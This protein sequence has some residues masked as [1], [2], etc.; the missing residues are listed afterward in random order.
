[1]PDS[2]SQDHLRRIV[3]AC[4]RRELALGAE[5]PGEDVELVET[6]ILD[7]MAWVSFIRS[8]ESTTGISDAGSR[9]ADRPATITNVLAV[10][11]DRRFAGQTREVANGSKAGEKTVAA[12]ALVGSA[13]QPGSR[14]VPSEIVDREYGMPEGKL[15]KRAGIESVA[16]AAEG[17]NEV[18]LG[19]QAANRALQ[20]A[21][22]GAQKID[23][24]LA[25]SET[26][27]AYP[28]IGAEL[29]SRLL[30]RETCGVLDIGGACLGFLNALAAAHALI[31]AGTGRVILIV[32]ADVHSRVLTP[33]R[34]SG[35]FGGLFGDGASA[36]LLQREAEENNSYGYSCRLGEFSFGCA[37]Q[38]A[39]AIRVAHT[40]DG[41]LEVGFAGDALSRAAVTRLEKILIEL[42]TRSGISRGQVGAFATH[43]PNPRLVELLARQLGVS[44]EKFPPI[45]RSYG[46][47][48]STTCAAALHAALEQQSGLP[49]AER[50]PIFLASLGPGLLWGG[51]WIEPARSETP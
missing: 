18:T 28:S 10:L 8:V 46:N 39:S 19:V 3:Q 13:V 29:H 51:G 45:A 1:M 11:A 40:Q 16:R 33:D 44:P 48:G 35:E 9:L 47:L 23:W 17:E 4:L 2:V 49:T 6:G 37:G 41:T 22:C 30:A 26:H 50:R 14:T 24:I 34:V 38:Y 43:Q 25:T 27:H 20:S 36:F 5:L 31:T 42:E 7:S 15:R 32:T 21:R 12:V